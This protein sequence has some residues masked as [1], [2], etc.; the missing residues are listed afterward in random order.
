MLGSSDLQKKLRHLFM[1]LR[2]VK[3][4][5][6]VVGNFKVDCNIFTCLIIANSETESKTNHLWHSE[7]STDDLSWYN[8]RC[9]SCLSR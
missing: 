6:T 5:A 2:V 7:F 1:I 9:F 3:L 4:Q 8:N